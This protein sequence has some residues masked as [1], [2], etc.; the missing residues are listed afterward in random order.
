MNKIN[1]NNGFSLIEIVLVT[2]LI[3]LFSLGVYIAYTRVNETSMAANE[4][5]SMRGI[6]GATRSLIGGSNLV[7]V[8]DAPLLAQ[9]R[10]IYNEQLSGTNYISSLGKI[11][12]FAPVFTSGTSHIRV[13]YND[14]DETYCAKLA[15][16]FK[17]DVDLITVNGAVVYN[18]MPLT[19]SVPLDISNL[20]TACAA[21]GPSF[22][23][24][25][26]FKR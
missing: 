4:A 11:V 13:S 9:A 14:M 7:P 21:G 25:F 24:S 15:I 1:K 6:I 26:N 12:T 23:Q 22:V 20:A 8:L 10:I 3:A 2:G 19:T 18:S 5:R 17:N 16:A